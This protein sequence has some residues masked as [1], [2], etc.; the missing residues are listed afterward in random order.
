M[1]DPKPQTEKPKASRGI[2]ARLPEHT[3]AEM[4]EANQDLNM[5]LEVL[6]EIVDAHVAGALPPGKV[7]EL[8]VARR[9]KDDEELLAKRAPVPGGR[10]GGAL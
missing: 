6:R 10:L 5:P 7:T 9:R 3:S 8:V 1:T 4:R 2:T